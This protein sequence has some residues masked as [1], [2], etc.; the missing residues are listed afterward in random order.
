MTAAERV[1]K[2]QRDFYSKLENA[3][4]TNDV[5]CTYSLMMPVIINKVDYLRGQQISIDEIDK[6][7]LHDLCTPFFTY[8]MTT[9][10]YNGFRD[11]VKWLSDSVD[12]NTI[13]EETEAFV[14]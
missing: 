2:Q 11:Y 13:L 10:L 3:R 5:E 1:K 7:I 4:N 8:D 14:I 12:S 9:R 6:T